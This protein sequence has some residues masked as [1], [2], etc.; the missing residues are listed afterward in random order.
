MERGG[1]GRGR[2]G[3]RGQDLAPPPPNPQE[4]KAPPTPLNPQEIDIINDEVEEQ[5][6]IPKTELTAK[7][8]STVAETRTSTIAVEDDRARIGVDGDSAVNS[9][10]YASTCRI[11]NDV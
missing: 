1:R 5:E 9:I 10:F 6:Q 8:P 4:E 3:R 2:R 7:P 11:D